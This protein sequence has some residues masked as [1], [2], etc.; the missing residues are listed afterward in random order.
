V[1]T[2]TFPL[3]TVACTDEFKGSKAMSAILRTDTGRAV[4]S[5]AREAT[6]QSYALAV[7]ALGA[8]SCV[9]FAAITVFTTQSPGGGAFH[10]QADY[11]YTAIGIPIALAEI[12]LLST[13]R[14]L[15]AGRDGKLASIGMTINAIALVVLTAQL[16]YSLAVGSESSWGPTYPIAVLVTLI[17]HGLFSA[18]SWKVGLMPRWLLAIWPVVWV[19]GSFAAQSA[20]PLLLTALYAAIAIVLTRKR[21]AE[22]NPSATPPRVPVRRA[23]TAGT[24]SQATPRWRERFY[25]RS[26]IGR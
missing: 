1:A 3:P 22:T 18:G 9:A 11:W 23:T 21:H 19:I 5:D 25:G 6:A 17:G 16:V 13:M 12:V 20:T 26:R 15:Q 4:E 24:S 10:H 2:R 14:V 8:A 7:L